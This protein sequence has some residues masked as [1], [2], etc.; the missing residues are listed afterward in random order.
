LHGFGDAVRAEECG[1]DGGGDGSGKR[2]GAASVATAFRRRGALVRRESKYARWCCRQSSAMGRS[3]RGSSTTR[4]FP[5]RGGT[6]LAWRGNTAANS[7]SGIIVRLQCRCRSPI[8]MRACRWPI[9]YICRKTGRRIAPVGARRVCPRRSASK[10]SHRSRLSS[11]VGRARLP[12]RAAWHCWTPATAP[13]PI[14]VRTSRR[15]GC[16]T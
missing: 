10:P 3:M 7:A 9:S 14:C 16:G 8:T 2:W 13:T 4:V 11:C 5:S 12:C 15:W 1:A 6:R